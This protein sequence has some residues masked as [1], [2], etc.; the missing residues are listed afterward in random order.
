MLIRFDLYSLY[1][2]SLS[3]Y[4]VLGAGETEMNRI[5]FKDSRLLQAISSLQLN[6]LPIQMRHG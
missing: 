3:T 6:V 1:F 5:H 4:Y 2:I